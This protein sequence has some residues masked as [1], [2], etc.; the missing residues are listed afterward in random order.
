MKQVHAHEVESDVGIKTTMHVDPAHHTTMVVE[1]IGHI[2]IFSVG[3]IAAMG[4][5]IHNYLQT[6][7][8]KVKKE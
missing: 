5:L 6:R 2:L 7:Q 1:H 8:Q 3:L 4:L